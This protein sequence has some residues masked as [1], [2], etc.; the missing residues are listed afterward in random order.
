MEEDSDP[1]VPRSGES[2]LH[3]DQRSGDVCH[4]DPLPYE[5]RAQKRRCT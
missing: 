5:C 3:L 4:P 2:P 1:S